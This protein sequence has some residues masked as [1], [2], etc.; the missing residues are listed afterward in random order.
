MDVY[1]R[2]REENP[3]NG[4]SGGH[5]PEPTLEQ[6]RNELAKAINNILCRFVPVDYG[7]AVFAI[8]ETAIVE[9]L[10]SFEANLIRSKGD[11]TLVLVEIHERL[12][13]SKES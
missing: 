9:T 1:R 6:A 2:S 11:L 12:F 4:V 10:K 8:S 13:Q 5:R 7:P 3:S